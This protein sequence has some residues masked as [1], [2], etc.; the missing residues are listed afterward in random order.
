[1]VDPD[2]MSL[3]DIALSD[4]PVRQG[5]RPRTTTVNPQ[6]QLDQQPAMPLSA[7]LIERIAS[8]PGVNLGPSGRAPHGTIGF[9]LEAEVG[10]GPTEAFMLER[11]F[12]HVHPRP[13]HSLHMTLPASVRERAIRAGWATPHPMAGYPTVSP[14]LVMV[15][16]PR[17]ASEA[18]V[19]TRLLTAA[20][21]F[22]SGRIAN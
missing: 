20:W 21:G 2:D 13:D 8:L 9:Y 6:T 15:Y 14:N 10:S 12:A 4:L 17:D 22:A 19:V 1:M 16:A 18:E 5:P 3:A 7:D 11:E